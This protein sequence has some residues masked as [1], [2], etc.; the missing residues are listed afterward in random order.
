MT[1]DRLTRAN[2]VDLEVR[3]DGRT[4]VGIAVPFDRSTPIRDASGSYDESFRRGAFARTIRERGDRVKFLA[5]HDRRS[6][7][8]GRA[9]MLR[10]DAAGLYAEFRVSATTAGDEALELIRD[11]ALDALS[12]GFRP[13]RDRWS[14]DRST[15][16]RLEVRLDEVSA[17][18]FPAYSDALIAAVRSGLPTIPAEVARRRLALLTRKV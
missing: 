18:A 14:A 15:V 3:G 7:P 10:E 6:L 17:V 4:V 13:I 12:I 8:L 2:P 5:Q 1:I 16:E 9:H 11:G